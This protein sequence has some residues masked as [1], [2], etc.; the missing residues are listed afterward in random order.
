MNH[1]SHSVEVNTLFRKLAL[2]EMEST[3]GGNSLI[4]LWNSNLKDFYLSA[5][6]D[7]ENKLSTTSF[8]FYNNKILTI[9]FSNLN[10]YLVV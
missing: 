6:P 1:K 7:W 3:V 5:F 2:E 4:P 8:G 10:I 9:D